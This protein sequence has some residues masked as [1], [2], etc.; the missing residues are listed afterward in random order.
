M[1]SKQNQIV[2][3]ETNKCSRKTWESCNL[4]GA[5]NYVR[6]IHADN[7]ALCNTDPPTEQQ[8]YTST[9]RPRE[10]VGPPMEVVARPTLTPRGQ[11]LIILRTN[12]QPHSRGHRA[13]AISSLWLARRET[14]AQER[15]GCC[16]G[17]PAGYLRGGLFDCVAVQ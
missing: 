12:F 15:R 4:R 14:K 7:L 6:H 1:V 16:C 5:Q 17:S 2:N 3:R 11:T 8:A 10:V 13:E 9:V